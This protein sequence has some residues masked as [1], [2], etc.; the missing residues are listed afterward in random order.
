MKSSV[1][2][3]PQSAFHKN[4]GIQTNDRILSMRILD[5]ENQI[6]FLQDPQTGFYVIYD[7]ESSQSFYAKSYIDA[8]HRFNFL[9]GKS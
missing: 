6:E 3:E 7:S 1:R 8:E 4:F 2:K 9:I 5:K